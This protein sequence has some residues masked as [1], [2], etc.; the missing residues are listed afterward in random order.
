[1]PQYNYAGKST[2]VRAHQHARRIPLLRVI[3]ALLEQHLPAG[4]QNGHGSGNRRFYE[5]D[6]GSTRHVSRLAP[7]TPDI[8]RKSAAAKAAAIATAATSPTPFRRRPTS[9]TINNSQISGT[10]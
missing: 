9:S 10:A 5:A 3:A 6:S 8:N 1:M 7:S 2:R 4:Q